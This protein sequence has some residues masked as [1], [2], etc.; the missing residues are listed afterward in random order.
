MSCAIDE[1]E[2]ALLREKVGQLERW[3]IR[4]TTPPAMTVEVGP[5]TIPIAP[6]HVVLP[7]IDLITISSAPF[8]V[9]VHRGT[10]CLVPCLPVPPAGHV[11]IA[12]VYVHPALT[13]I[14]SG[15]IEEI[16][17]DVTRAIP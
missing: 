3:R 4:A 8:A 17:P 15:A 12:S 14:M 1:V 11:R 2:L 5:H 9:H 16:G 10:P 13:C 7:R 6:S